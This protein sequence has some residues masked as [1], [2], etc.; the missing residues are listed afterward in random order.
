[1]RAALALTLATLA[2]T[3]AAAQPEAPKAPAKLAAGFEQR[4]YDLS[5]FMERVSDYPGPDIQMHPPSAAAGGLAG[6]TFTLEEPMMA[7]G[8]TE[9]LIDLIRSNIAEDSWSDK[10]TSIQAVGE[11]L[12]VIQAPA[13]HAKIAGLIAYLRRQTELQVAVEGTVALVEDALLDELRAGAPQ[14]V[15]LTDAA[16]KALREALAKGERAT[17]VRSSRATARNGQRVHFAA[18]QQRSYVQ[19][20]DIAVTSGAMACDPIVGYLQ[21]GAVL[22]VVPRFARGTLACGIRFSHHTAPRPLPVFDTG[23]PGMG[24]LQLPE[25]TYSCVETSVT[26]VDGQTLLAGRIGVADPKA[27]A[28]P[29]RSLCFLVRPALVPLEAVP[30]PASEEKRQVRIYDVGILTTGLRDFTAPTLSLIPDGGACIMAEESLR[31]VVSPETLVESIRHNIAPESWENTRNLIETHEHILYVR[32]SPDVLDAIG[33]YLD[34]LAARRWRMIA[35]RAD[36]LAADEAGA[37]ALLEKYPSLAAGVM[38]M[39]AA[40]A[41]DLLTRAAKGDGV[42]RLASGEVAGM[43][44]QRVNVRQMNQVAYVRDY[45]TE[46]ATLVAAQDPQVDIAQEGVILDCRPILTGDGKTIHAELRFSVAQLER[47]VAVERVDGAADGKGIRAHRPSLSLARWRTMVVASAGDCYLV[48]GG[49]PVKIGG[50]EKTL[51]AIIR[52]APAP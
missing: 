31:E 27:P 35:T 17:L 44:R 18:L 23:L 39:D 15:A 42:S 9:I 26:G 52:L 25:T 21:L 7:G 43:N 49:G 47:P 13:I 51:F 34:D 28:G 36:V 1:M 41:A 37:R 14:A 38:R 24:L 12:V 32:Q 2:A 5:V 3:P 22:D 8:G 11:E 46:L 40:E 16:A 10:R 29:P 6:A 4:V 19:D 30:A 50:A 33:K 48:G 20:Y 45:D